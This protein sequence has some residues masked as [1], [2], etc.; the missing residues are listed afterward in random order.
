MSNSPVGYYQYQNNLTDANGNIQIFFDD[1]ID[2]TTYE[3]YITVANIMPYYP[4]LIYD[5]QQVVQFI[6]S[7]PINPNTGNQSVG[8]NQIKAISPG[9]AQA[10]KKYILKQGL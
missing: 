8:Y 7:T 6:L 10:L 1:L 2:G 4:S 9:L 3:V 5:D